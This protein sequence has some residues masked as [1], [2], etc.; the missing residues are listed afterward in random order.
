[1][2]S[3]SDQLVTVIVCVYNAG[4]YLRP[5]IQSLLEQTHRNIEIMIVDDGSTDGCMETIQDLA[6]P[7]IVRLHQENQGKSVA[8]N[9]A[10]DRIRGEFYAVHDAD[11]LSDPRR[12]ERQLAAM[13]AHPDL[14]AVFSGYE[15]VLGNT[16]MAPLARERSVEECRREIMAFRMPSHDPTV[17]YRWSMVADLRYDPVLRIGQGFDYILRVGERSPMMVLGECLYSYRIH[18]DSNTKR[19][20]ARRQQ[21]VEM[22]LRNARERR[23]IAGT[24]GSGSPSTGR[25]RDR[26]NNLAAHFIES[27]CVQKQFGRLGGALKAG[28]QCLALNPRDLHYWKALI[29]A[30]MPCPM[31]RRIRLARA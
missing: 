31:L 9:Q 7:R 24:I 5:S 25:G 6:D 20:P 3:T 8:L 23:G 18:R 19:D 29:Y 27:V 11:D 16:R 1:M 14:A 15:V 28:I 10:L 4:D 12:I 26:D 2:S 22:V 17:M 13:Q 30:S 21:M